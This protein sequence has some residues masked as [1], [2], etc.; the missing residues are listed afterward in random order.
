MENLNEKGGQWKNDAIKSDDK[1]CNGDL[2]LY[3]LLRY[4]TPIF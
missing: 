4:L 1:Q 3:M 2:F